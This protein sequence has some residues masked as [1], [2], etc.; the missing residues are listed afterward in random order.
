MQLQKIGEKTQNQISRF[1]NSENYVAKT[2]AQMQEGIS[3]V[4]KVCER[5]KTCNQ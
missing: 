4:L 2:E 5:G 1:A 3:R